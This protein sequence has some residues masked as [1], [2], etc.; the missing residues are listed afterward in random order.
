MTV[1]EFWVGAGM[2][3]AVGAKIKRFFHRMDV[4]NTLS[5]VGIQ[6]IIEQNE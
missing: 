2:S 3:W 4:W 6:F 5:Y 1:D